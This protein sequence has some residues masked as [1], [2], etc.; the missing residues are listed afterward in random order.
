MTFLKDIAGFDT[1]ISFDVIVY[2]SSDR[3]FIMKWGTFN[4]PQ[5][6]F[7]SL[8]DSWLKNDPK[9]NTFKVFNYTQ[10]DIARELGSLINP[11]PVRE[12]Q[13]IV[14]VVAIDITTAIDRIDA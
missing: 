3:R 1:R 10:V 13:H 11:F 8:F 4:G 7:Q 9:P 12:R 2:V 6:E 5:R 14:F